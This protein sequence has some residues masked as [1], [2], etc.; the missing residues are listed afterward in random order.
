[1]SLSDINLYIGFKTTLLSQIAN[2]DTVDNISSTLTSI[3]SKNTD[4][5]GGLSSSTIL[6]D[7]SGIT[8]VDKINFISVVDFCQHSDFDLDL[9]LMSW[10]NKLTNEL[11][12]ATDPDIIAA[13]TIKLAAATSIFQA[14]IQGQNSKYDT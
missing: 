2:D 4:I 6:D 3:A 10:L 7:G 14:I 9:I 1:M 13:L 11:K 12:N 5:L 8:T